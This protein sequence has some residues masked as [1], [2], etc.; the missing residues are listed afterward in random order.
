MF[1]FGCKFGAG[2]QYRH[3]DLCFALGARHSRVQREQRRAVGGAGE[4]SGK[5]VAAL[6]SAEQGAG[7]WATPSPTLSIP[8]TARATVSGYRQLGLRSPAFAS[9]TREQPASS[10]KVMRTGQPV[11]SV[12][13]VEVS[14]SGQSSNQ[15]DLFLPMSR[16]RLLTIE[17]E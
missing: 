3:L 1:V 7:E 16:A 5:R 14:V 6:R 11:H 12:A 17:W 15:E 8:S 10:L 13:T 2:F 4:P 9:P